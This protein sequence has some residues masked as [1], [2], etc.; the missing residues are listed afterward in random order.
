DFDSSWNA[1]RKRKNWT[2]NAG[3]A[4]AGSPQQIVGDT[5]DLTQQ[6]AGSHGATHGRRLPR[7]QLHPVNIASAGARG[8][9]TGRETALDRIRRRSRRTRRLERPHILGGH[10]PSEPSGPRARQPRAVRGEIVER[11]SPARRRS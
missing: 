2:Y 8:S 7:P 6:I 9:H 5:P 4:E 11:T 10:G 1:P 3:P